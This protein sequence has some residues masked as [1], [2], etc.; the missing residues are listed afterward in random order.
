MKT[1]KNGF[2]AYSKV[3]DENTMNGL[4]DLVDKKIDNARDLIL[5]CDFSINP[6]HI[7]GDKEITGCKFCKYKDICF[8]NNDNIVNLKKYKDLSFLNEGD[9]DA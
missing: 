1:T 8:R 3:L 9:D 6:K 4:I 2:G 5:D 7:S